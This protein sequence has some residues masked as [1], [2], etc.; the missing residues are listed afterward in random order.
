MIDLKDLG[1]HVNLP[2]GADIVVAMTTPTGVTAALSAAGTLNGTYYYRVSASDGVGWTTLSS[3]V[4]GTVDGGT[5]NGTITVS[6]DAVTGATKYRVWR[7]TT[8][9]GESEYYETTATSLAD[10]GSLTFTAGTIPT[11]T[12]AYVNQILA[13]GSIKLGS[14]AELVWNLAPTAPSTGYADLRDR[15]NYG[16]AI[17]AGSS[18]LNGAFMEFYGKNTTSSGKQP[19]DLNISYGTQALAAATAAAQLRITHRSS[20]NGTVEVLYGDYYGNVGFGTKTP[21]GGTTVGTKVLSIADG[22][23]PA[24]GVSGQSSLYSS[25]GELYAFDSGGTATLLSPHKF[26]LF[27]PDP[28]YELPFSYYSVNKFI[29]K[30]VNVDM[31]GAIRALEKLT[32]KK[33]IYIE[34]LPPEEVIDWDENEEKQRLQREKEIEEWDKRKAEIEKTANPEELEDRLKELGERPKPYVKR[35]PPKWIASRLKKPSKLV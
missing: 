22:T 20:D 12:T 8:A 31:Y 16:V 10:D 19:G 26:E 1:Q 17:H 15:L 34:D 13:S 6:W 24:G 18:Y 25:S 7:G 33:F 30:K 32:G 2:S 23:A 29:G 27:D 35:T 4:S 14:T 11:A 5:T 9:G 21:G 3:E 28:T